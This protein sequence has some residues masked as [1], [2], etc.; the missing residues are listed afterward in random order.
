MS[1]M[2]FFKSILRSYDKND[3]LLLANLKIKTPKYHWIFH[4]SEERF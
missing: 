2:D 4:V 3:F 1:H